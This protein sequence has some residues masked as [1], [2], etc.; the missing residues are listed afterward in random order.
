MQNAMDVFIITFTL[1]ELKQK[2]STDVTVSGTYTFPYL[3]IA[4]VLERVIPS[5]KAS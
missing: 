3:H 2:Y 1:H 5:D 4:P